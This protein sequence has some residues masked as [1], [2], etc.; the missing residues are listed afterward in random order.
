[1]ARPLL[2]SPPVEQA[3]ITATGRFAPEKI[4]T[5]RE[6]AERIRERALAG[7]DAQAL[8]TLLGVV[9][10]RWATRESAP[11]L[12]SEAARKA[13]HRA[14]LDPS[15]LDYVICAASTTDGA[16]ARADAVRDE[17]GATSARTMDIRTGCRAYIDA[18]R[19]G[20]LLVD[21]HKAE[22]VL[23]AAGVK[24]CPKVEALLESDAPNPNDL[25]ALAYGDAGA[26]AIIERSGKPSAR[27]VTM[28]SVSEADGAAA[29]FDS[30]ALM[31]RACIS[32][33]RLIREVL[34][35]LSW[36]PRDIGWV[37]G[38]QISAGV[39]KWVAGRAGIP[40]ERCLHSMDLFGNTQAAGIPF[41]FDRM[42]EESRPELGRGLFVAGAG[43]VG[44]A[45]LAMELA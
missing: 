25:A 5:T 8:E 28:R 11:L 37:V 40:V 27:M 10:R 7:V 21:A 22:R 38:P 30:Q 18:L 42:L 35:E 17:L 13:L 31:R 2:F 1:M 41:T 6:L 3:V 23:V 32:V 34:E 29:E 36:S 20:C 43:G 44:A 39:T 16:G 24:Q 12:A 15:R 45:V 19:Y 4:V 14:E 26:A 9:E 33:G